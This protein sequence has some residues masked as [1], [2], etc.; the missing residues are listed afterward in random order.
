MNGGE[1]KRARSWVEKLVPGL[2][3]LCALEAQ[4][5]GGTV[6][7]QHP[8]VLALVSPPM[9][10]RSSL[11]EEAGQPRARAYL[12]VLS[13]AERNPQRGMDP[14]SGPGELRLTNVPLL[15]PR[16]A[17]S[18]L[19]GIV[20]EFVHFTG[21]ISPNNSQ[22]QTQAVQVKKAG[23]KLQPLEAFSPRDLIKAEE[24]WSQN[25]WEKCPL[26][27]SFGFNLGDTG[28]PQLVLFLLPFSGFHLAPL[29]YSQLPPLL[30]CEFQGQLKVKL[31]HVSDRNAS[32]CGWLG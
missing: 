8:G 32:R 6:V 1:S 25:N 7:N 16:E 3:C 10:N 28:Q 21:K 15:G 2:S 20:A 13:G 24:C 9:V 31:Y 18:D 30:G 22:I 19:E 4:W 14:S 17:K 27:C 23:R 12:E 29:P 5:G 26:I 11:S